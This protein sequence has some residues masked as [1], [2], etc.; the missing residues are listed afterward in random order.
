MKTPK[1]KLTMRQNITL[2]G[3]GVLSIASAIAVYDKVRSMITP[4]KFEPK[5]ETIRYVDTSAFELKMDKLIVDKLI[6][7]VKEIG[8]GVTCGNCFVGFCIDN[9]RNGDATP[10]KLRE[11]LLHAKKDY[12]SAL[13]ADDN[14]ELVE[15]GVLTPEAIVGYITLKARNKTVLLEAVN[16]IDWLINEIDYGKELTESSFRKLNGYVGQLNG[17]SDELNQF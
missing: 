12:K 14:W 1:Q 9:I 13:A 5:T 17:I 2:I 8:F 15:K 7:K 4:E 10:Q 11:Y 3:I 16:E 6:G